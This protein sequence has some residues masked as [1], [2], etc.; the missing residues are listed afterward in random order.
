MVKK[1]WCFIWGHKFVIKSFTGQTK[2][3]INAFRGE[4][5]IQ[6]Y[7]WSKTPFCLR[8]CKP[9][10]YYDELKEKKNENINP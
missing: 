1:L 8:C 6:Y 2:K 3:V 7:K 5:D 9:N 4:E 10:P